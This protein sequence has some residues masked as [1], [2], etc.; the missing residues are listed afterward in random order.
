MSIL[1]K[2]IST[3]TWSP[4]LTL[5]ADAVSGQTLQPT[6]F[7]PTAV[8]YTSTS[9]PPATLYYGDEF[10]GDSGTPTFTI[11]LTSWLDVEG[12]A[13]NGTGMK[14]QEIRIQADSSNSAVVNLAPGGSNGYVLFGT[15]ND[16]DVPA[17]GLVH[18]RFDD[19]LADISASLKNLTLTLGH[20]DICSIEIVMG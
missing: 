15:S 7:N 1:T 16:I 5:A 13:K 2:L 6:H 3:S 19:E 10:T 11:D 18:A 20:G 12:I 4:T 8:T 9:T 17:G 14:V